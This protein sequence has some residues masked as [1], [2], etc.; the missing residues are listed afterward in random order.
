L[1]FAPAVA[2]GGFFALGFP[3]GFALAGAALTCFA[4]TDFALAGAALAGFALAG[5]ALAGAAVTGFVLAGA[6]LAGFGMTLP[7]RCDEAPIPLGP[8]QVQQLLRDARKSSKFLS[9]STM[10][11][12]FTTSWRAYLDRLHL[13]FLNHKSEGTEGHPEG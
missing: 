9:L 3:A 1:L 5:F 11:R 8:S 4:L 7:P 6:A 13:P 2:A 10:A 12:E